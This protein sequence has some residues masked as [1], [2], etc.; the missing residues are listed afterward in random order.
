MVLDRPQDFQLAAV[1]Q[2]GQQGIP[3]SVLGG[4]GGA[5][6]DVDPADAGKNPVKPETGFPL[7]CFLPFLGDRLRPRARRGALEDSFIS[8]TSFARSSFMRSNA[9]RARFRISRCTCSSR[10]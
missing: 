5:A 6:D 1:V 4:R 2:L 7:H 3:A 10:T 8:F 9:P